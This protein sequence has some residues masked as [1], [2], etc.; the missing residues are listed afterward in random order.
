MAYSSSALHALAKSGQVDYEILPYS[1]IAVEL[2][3]RLIANEEFAVQIALDAALNL[4][5]IA[6]D[7]ECYRRYS[8]SGKL[9]KVVPERIQMFRQMIYYEA[10]KWE[11]YQ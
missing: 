2:A 4:K 10:Q 8:K 5:R 1:S 7:K 9:T 11:L 3:Y 6:Y